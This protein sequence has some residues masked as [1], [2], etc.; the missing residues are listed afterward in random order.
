MRPCDS[1]IEPPLQIA[2]DKIRGAK[3]RIK[4]SILAATDPDFYSKLRAYQR[5]CNL[6]HNN[7][8]RKRK[9]RALWSMRIPDWAT[10]G[11]VLDG[12]SQFLSVNLT[13]AQRAYA[14]E[15][16]IERKSH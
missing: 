10:K 2:K 9:Y 8:T 3:R 7:R 15:L 13:P 1:K 16:A 12:R 14:R 11:S 5:L 6:R 4:K